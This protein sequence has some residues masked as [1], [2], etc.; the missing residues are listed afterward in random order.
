M[1]LLFD[2]NLSRSLCARLHD[3]FPGSE[4]AVAAGLKNSDDSSVWD[5]AKVR[6]LVIVTKDGDF[7][8]MSFLLGAPP[9]V[10]WRRMGNC[11]TDKVENLL[12]R[13]LKSLAR[14]GADDDAAILI[15]EPD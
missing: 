8:Q 12:R 13:N 5:Y 11:S 15:I 10:V 1:K 7:H 2:E 14:L 4:H 6:D 9:K 3:I